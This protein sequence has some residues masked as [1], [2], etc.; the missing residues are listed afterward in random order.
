MLQRP[1]L[2]DVA[3]HVALA[4]SASLLYL[5]VQPRPAVVDES[6]KDD[7]GTISQL[8]FQCQRLKLLD[9]ANVITLTAIAPMSSSLAL[10]AYQILFRVVTVKF[11]CLGR[12]QSDAGEL[13]FPRCDYH[14]RILSYKKFQLKYA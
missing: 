14:A 6:I 8:Q 11:C 2:E 3:Q 4:F 5:M 1:E 7:A 10:M 12:R 9:T 13:Q